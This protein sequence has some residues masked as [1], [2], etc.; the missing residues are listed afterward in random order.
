MTKL[1]E[2]AR[3]QIPDH[4][5]WKGSAPDIPWEDWWP[6]DH[7]WLCMALQEKCEARG[8]RIN[9]RRDL[10]EIMVERDT[11]DGALWYYYR[12]ETPDTLSRIACLVEALEAGNG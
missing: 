7:A 3:A 10:F 11:G 12:A 8:Y 1:I 2:R 4:R 5:I 9:I 6:G